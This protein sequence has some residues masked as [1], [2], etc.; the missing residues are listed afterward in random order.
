ML[1]KMQALGAAVLGG[2]LA[3]V[4]CSNSDGGT[5]SGGAG[6]AAAGST[7]SGQGGTGATAGKSGAA[8]EAPVCPG[9][10]SGFCLPDGTCVDCLASNDQCPAGQYCTDTNTCAPG[11]KDNAT[12][13]A[14]GVCLDSHDCKSCISDDECT[15][16]NVCGAGLCAPAC[17][18]AQEG[19]HTGCAASLTC[20]SSHCTDVATD[21]NH[22]GACGTACGDSQFCGLTTGCTDTGEAGAGGAGPDAC[23]AC[24][25]TT[26]A[27][28]CSISRVVVI[29]DTSKNPTDGNRT[30]GRAIGAAL[31]T[32]CQPTP[33]LSEEEQDTPDALN[34]TTGHPVSGGGT[35]LVVAGG[36]FYQNLEGYFEQSTSPLYVTS[37]GD[38]QEFIN[39]ATGAVVVS[40]SM[41]A[42]NLS[43]DFFIIQF[44]RDASSGSLVLNFQGFWESGT[45][46][47][48]FELVN[49]ILPALSTYDKS[50]YAYEWTDS[51]GGDMAPE[52][53]EI[54]LKASGP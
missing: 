8:G 51:V 19:E 48:A 36:F 34:I 23:V 47:A 1:N 12:S 9:C 52:L 16:G 18:A 6:G 29:L 21:S 14:S 54:T 30:P 22:C 43:H 35:L 28:I 26:L 2:L 13:C 45:T 3:S 49:V 50:W 39:R 46:A 31:N 20:C 10:A 53:N 38:T 32:Q 44:M 42:D 15:A 24:L 17:A 40:R 11:C 5:T 25:D 4:A 7:S 37:V 41:S 27:N 33:V